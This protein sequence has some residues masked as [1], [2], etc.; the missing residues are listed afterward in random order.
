MILVAY[1]ICWLDIK[2]IFRGFQNKY[3]T[4]HTLLHKDALK[5]CNLPF[6]VFRSVFDIQRLSLMFDAKVR[7][8]RS[9][10]VAHSYFTVSWHHIHEYSCSHSVVSASEQNMIRH[11]LY[12]DVCPIWITIIYIYTKYKVNSFP[13]QIKKKN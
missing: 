1:F 9:S 5:L 8:K 7:H 6:S 2:N 3:F 4:S 11:P 10:R 13:S 12:C